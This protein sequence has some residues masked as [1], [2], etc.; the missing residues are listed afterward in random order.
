MHE[1]QNKDEI[2]LNFII[3]CFYEDKQKLDMYKKSTEEYNSEIKKLMSKLDK[4]EFETD[5]GLVAKINIQNRE[6][7]ID[8]KL[9]EKIKELNVSG[10]I[11]TKEYVD[12][13]ELEDA[14]YNGR[15]NASELTNCKTSK[16]VITLKVSQRKEK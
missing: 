9:I 16:E 8:D 11:K 7:F 14:I 1:N 12:I 4:N 6:S 5:D 3:Q 2:A 13:D 15:I 10:I